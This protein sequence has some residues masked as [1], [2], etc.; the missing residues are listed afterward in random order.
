M[1]DRN[2]N[3]PSFSQREYEASIVSNLPVSPPS[4][5]MQLTADDKDIGE[6]AKILYTIV[7]GNEK[8]IK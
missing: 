2:D 5:V 7:A 4:S 8:G 3:P 1:E 6:N